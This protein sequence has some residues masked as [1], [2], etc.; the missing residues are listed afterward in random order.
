MTRKWLW[1]LGILV[2]GTAV[3]TA[4]ARAQCWLRPD[5]ALLSTDGST[6]D[7]AMPDPGSGLI[8]MAL[9]QDGTVGFTESR[10]KSHRPDIPAT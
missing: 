9:T 2:L 4:L 8:T 5:Q 3:G 1:T 10:P 6:M 7:L